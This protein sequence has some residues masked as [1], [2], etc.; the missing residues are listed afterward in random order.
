MNVNIC[1]TASIR[2][3]IHQNRLDQSSA[4]GGERGEHH[5]IYVKPISTLLQNGLAFLR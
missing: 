2:S 1:E 3:E 4:S 5:D